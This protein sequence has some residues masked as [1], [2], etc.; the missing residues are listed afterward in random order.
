MVREMDLPY[1]GDRGLTVGTNLVEA[2]HHEYFEYRHQRA[3]ERDERDAFRG[4]ETY[5]TK[6][7]F[8]AGWFAVQLNEDQTV[9][10][11]DNTSTLA[12]TMPYASNGRNKTNL[13]FT[14]PST[15]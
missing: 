10:T 8:T 11:I 4:I 7:L 12:T 5:D 9:I 3:I 13:P 14:A 15:I 2:F 1:H 6:P